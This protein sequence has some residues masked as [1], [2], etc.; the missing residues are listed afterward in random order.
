MPELLAQL[1]RGQLWLSWS[2]LFS[3]VVGYLLAL[4][5]YRLFFHPLVGFP[6]PWLAAITYLYES[7]YD[8]VQGGQYTFKIRDLHREYGMTPVVKR[9]PS[10]SQKLK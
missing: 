10:Q 2:A 7:Y 1:T 8:I 9:R 6:G 3:G 4:V 5:I